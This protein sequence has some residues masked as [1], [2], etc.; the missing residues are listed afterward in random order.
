MMR[1]ALGTVV[2]ATLL[3]GC[4]GLT[5]D[6]DQADPVLAAADLGDIGCTALVM[7]GKPSDVAQ[8]RQALAAA[9]AVL[10]AD[11]PTVALLAA[12]LAVA[13]TD[14]R[15]QA[16]GRV[17]VRRI[18]LRLGTADPLPKDSVAFQMAAAFVEACGVALGEGTLALAPPNCALEYNTAGTTI[19]SYCHV[20]D[21]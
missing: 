9:R 6:T 4:A 19:A 20:V 3:A 14:P 18:Q 10:A 15:W 11:S 16:L 13:D 8:A 1:K 12:A 7:E 5:S 21:G 2:L 17:V